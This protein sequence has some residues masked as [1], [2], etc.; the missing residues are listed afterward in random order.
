MSLREHGE[1]QV[2]RRT[3][4]RW[5]SGIAAAMSAALVGVPSLLAFLAPTFRRPA[6]KDWIKV[7][8]AD[9]V[10]IETPVKVDFVE[11]LSDAWIESRALRTIWLYTEDG[12]RFTAFNGTCT[13]LGCSYGY[14]A[15][16]KLF[17]CPCHQGVF[18]MK[19]GAVLAGPP[20]RAL[21]PLPVRVVDGEV[22]VILRQF[23]PG[24]AERIEV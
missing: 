16:R 5:A 11:P 15:S 10:E 13:H 2:P 14:D 8:Q 19:T 4:L 9:L 22:Q 3:F 17:V 21:D 12:E 6:K 1:V 24:V 7:A 23:R 20:P 18:D